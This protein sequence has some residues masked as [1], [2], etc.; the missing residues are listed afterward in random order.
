[1]TILVTGGAGF[2]GANF[3]L[4]WFAKS[5][6]PIVNVDALTYAGNLF[7]LTEIGNDSRYFFEKVDI[8]DEIKVCR[9]LDKYQPRAIVHF[10]AESHVDRSIRGPHAFLRTNVQGT[11][12][13]LQA[14][15]G[16]WR[17]LSAREKSAFRYVQVSTD[18]VY[19]SLDASE[20][21]F[22]EET[23][24]APNSPYAASKA[25]AD[26]FAR[27]Y[28]HTYGLPSIVT[29]CSNNYGRFQFPEKL[30]P[31]VILNSLSGRSLPIYG[32]G[33]NIR[34]WIH[35]ED[36]CT[37][38]RIVLDRGVAGENYNIGG[39][40]EVSNIDLVRN[41]CA[42]LDRLRPWSRGAYENLIDFV[43]DRPGHDRRYAVDNSKIERE[44]G[45][46]P[47]RTLERGLLQTVN[48]YL[49]N[50]SWIESVKSE[51]YRTWMTLN[52]NQSVPGGIV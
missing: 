23:R 38:L 47:T 46:N 3:I 5:E 28:Y 2:I 44:L 7:S 39:R 9:I 13:L 19:G 48:W 22:T 32:D 18:E 16:Y 42:I 49:S 24:F 35:V 8:C 45:W 4:D 36:H 12:A 37:A 6:E 21:P 14:T 15:L 52:Y 1:M 10:A 34:D 30:I 33:L 41:I 20:T 11:F 25:S 26:H 27:S 17:L 40:S 29:H 43:E 51:E 50:Q 31:L